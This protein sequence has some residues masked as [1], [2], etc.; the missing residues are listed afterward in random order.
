MQRLLLCSSAIALFF[1][2]GCPRDAVDVG[3]L[4]PVSLGG[5]GGSLPGTGGSAIGGA[6]S[7]GGAMVGA[8]GEAGAIG[9]AVG[10]GGEAG[11]IGGEVGMGGAAG[12]APIPGEL[13]A[14]C[15]VGIPVGAAQGTFNAAALDC[16]SGICLKPVDQTGVA[17]TQPLC[18]AGCSTDD[19]CA[20]LLRDA[21][22][23]SDKRCASGFTC[24]IA[25]V[26]GS[27]CCRNLCICKDFTGGPVTTVPIACQNG[28]ALTCLD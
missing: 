2:T 4:D 22:E 20:G 3:E 5:S 10:A 24:G 18:T 27:L 15:D 19:D 7:E 1:L 23:P 16:A 14:A 6:V 25:F 8:G 13:G 12:S 28:G 11:A 9:G 21:S 17:D 26:K